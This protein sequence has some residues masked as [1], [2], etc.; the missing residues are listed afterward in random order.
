[1]I[2]NDTTA[3]E[4]Q[5]QGWRERFFPADIWHG[6]WLRWSWIAFLLL[7][8]A[9]TAATFAAPQL[10]LL[11]GG[12][13]GPYV[14][15]PSD[16]PFMPL[17]FILEAAASVVFFKYELLYPGALAPWL[18]RGLW[19][20]GLLVE[21]SLGVA[22]V[23]RACLAPSEHPGETRPRLPRWSIRAVEGLL[24]LVGLF[25]L[26]LWL[27]LVWRVISAGSLIPPGA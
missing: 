16:L 4:S 22:F 21:L 24:A 7:H 27:A 15:R 17:D 23:V 25:I 3:T 2:T 1:M 26:A 12:E 10:G 5:D 20:A 11:Q 13:A 14:L 19:A 6:H 9:L 8:L 18:A